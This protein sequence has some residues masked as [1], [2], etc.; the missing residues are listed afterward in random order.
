VLGTHNIAY[1]NQDDKAKVPS[2][3]PVAI[4]NCHEHGIPKYQVKLPDHDFVTAAGRT[5]TP[6]VIA[7]LLL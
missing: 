7:G 2:G 3:L 1:F 5:F 4:N 6:N